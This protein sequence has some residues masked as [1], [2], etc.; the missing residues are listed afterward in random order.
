MINNQRVVRLR[1]AVL[2][3]RSVAMA[4]T[5][6]ILSS[7]LAFGLRDTGAQ[8]ENIAVVTA[9]VDSQTVVSRPLLSTSHTRRSSQIAIGPNVQVSKAR[10]DQPHQEVILAADPTNS[11]HLLAGSIVCYPPDETYKVI[12][13]ESLDGGVTWTISLEPARSTP[14]LGDMSDPTVAFGPEGEAYF[15]CNKNLPNKFYQT[16]TDIV[17]SRRSGQPWSSPI[18]I[19]SGLQMDRPYLT[20]DQTRGKFRGRV[21]CNNAT[22]FDALPGTGNTLTATGLYTSL[23]RGATFTLPTIRNL[24]VGS[25]QVDV[26]PNNS[27]VLSDGIVVVPYHLTMRDRPKVDNLNSPNAWLYVIR[28]LDGGTSIKRI[29]P[30][31]DEPKSGEHIVRRQYVTPFHNT[32][33]NIHTYHSGIPCLAVDASPL[34][35]KDRLYIVWDD[36]RENG[37]R[38]MFSSSQDKGF[39]WSAPIQIDDIPRPDGNKS[40]VE[41][42]M[43]EVAV[44]SSGVIGVSWYDTRDVPAGQEGWNLRFTA[45]LDGGKTWLPSRRVSDTSTLFT[46]ATQR[47]TPHKERRP[48][49]GAWYVGDTAG[50]AADTNGIFHPLWIDNRTGIRQ[51]WTATVT[52]G[53]KK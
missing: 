29:P 53:D 20:V 35:S 50:L 37:F 19:A 52:V 3:K 23:N 33:S 21:Y 49:E 32:T 16:S 2:Q 24:Q 45:S 12:V 14:D 36:D 1:G 5:L 22:L 10:A 31:E 47:R 38:T 4:F 30:R 43:P 44:N 41:A 6:T 48:P 7:T 13:Y 9:R 28:S 46:Q 27:V 40:R 34:A 18:T 26:H 15:G 51:V 42:F 39:T 8:T 11:R 25:S 17:Y